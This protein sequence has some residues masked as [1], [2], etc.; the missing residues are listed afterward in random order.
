MKVGISEW[1]INFKWLGRRYLGGLIHG[2]GIGVFIGFCI[3]FLI[4]LQSGWKLTSYNIFYKF[5]RSHLF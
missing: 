1:K 5:N 4:P 3:A 2:I